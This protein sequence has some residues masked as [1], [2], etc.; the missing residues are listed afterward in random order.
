MVFEQRQLRVRIPPMVEDGTLFRIGGEGSDGV[1]AGS[2]PGDLIVHAEVLSP[3]TDPRLV[4]YA[5]L[6]LLIIAVATLL[7]YTLR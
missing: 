3:P 1:A 2:I 4:R 6:V 5:A 7:L